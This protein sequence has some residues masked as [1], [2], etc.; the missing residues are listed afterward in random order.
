MVDNSMSCGLTAAPPIKTEAPGC[1]LQT[2]TAETVMGIFY[3][4]SGVYFGYVRKI[5]ACI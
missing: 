4:A 2:S 3:Y 5:F 1:F